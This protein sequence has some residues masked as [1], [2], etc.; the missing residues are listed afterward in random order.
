MAGEKN[1]TPGAVPPGAGPQYV[2][3]PGPAPPSTP[4]T[5]F[6]S[7]DFSV[8]PGDTYST[9]DVVIAAT[10]VAPVAPDLA[11]IA[12]NAFTSAEFQSL[13]DQPLRFTDPA[14]WKSELQQ[15]IDQGT[16][17]DFQRLLQR[18]AGFSTESAALAAD[19]SASDLSAEV[20]ARS[21]GR[22]GAAGAGLASAV[23]LLALGLVPGSL[24]PSDRPFPAFKG[25]PGAVG[26]AIPTS[27][28]NPGMEISVT[29]QGPDMGFGPAPAE[30]AVLPAPLP[31]VNVG[32][33]PF[34]LPRLSLG[35]TPFP[36]PFPSPTKGLTP[37]QSP[38]VGF[39]LPNPSQV[40]QRA[41]KPAR[42]PKTKTQMAPTGCDC[43]PRKKPGQCRQGYFRED[44]GGHTEFIT[45]S[46]RRCP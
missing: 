31:F 22:I 16:Q 32:P 6:G 11:S 14:A 26:G 9:P 4:G 25:R 20:T 27:L 36:T 12:P 42:A 8:P 2:F 44:S 35:P 18:P 17:S 37:F 39:G 33:S 24:S 1:W 41:P 3:A 29:P 46:T 21:L 7:Y 15:L 40:P 34:G 10:S 23:D 30:P 5:D 43:P 45:W 19:L 13:L 38:G 28:S